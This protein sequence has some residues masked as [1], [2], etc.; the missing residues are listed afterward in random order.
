M[1]KGTVTHTN[2]ILTH[3]L[4]VDKEEGGEKKGIINY[5]HYF[6][7]GGEEC[8]Y[9]IT[10]Y[11]YSTKTIKLSQATLQSPEPEPPLSRH[12]GHIHTHTHDKLTLTTLAGEEMSTFTQDVT[13]VYFIRI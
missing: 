6:I 2:I 7:C 4:Y 12:R 9:S 1:R 13:H 3:T 10:F 8:V 5:T 11:S